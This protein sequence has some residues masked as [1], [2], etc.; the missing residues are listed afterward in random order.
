MNTL[1]HAGFSN[2]S[3][4]RLKTSLLILFIMLLK[5]TASFSSPDIQTNASTPDLNKI[6]TNTKSYYFG[7]GNAF[8]LQKSLQE[9]SDNIESSTNGISLQFAQMRPL[10]PFL[11][12]E[13]RL[14]YSQSGGKKNG[15][16]SEFRQELFTLNLGMQFRLL[17]LNH[18]PYI[19]PKFGFAHSQL[20][21]R[22][23]SFSQSSSFYGM[24]IGY[25]LPQIWGLKIR[26][27]KS[28]QFGLY[29]RLNGSR[30]EQIYISL[31][32]N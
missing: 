28:Y 23:D 16:K 31:L 29:E 10:N 32:Y 11:S 20:Q 9:N 22:E 5:T 15:S 1:L 8:S 30:F 17:S 27:E 6:N 12:S 3:G 21:A 26:L 4:G 18:S 19:I 14:A 2:F 24:A 13:I 25:E 7:I